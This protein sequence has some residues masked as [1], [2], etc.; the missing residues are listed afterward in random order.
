MRS[1]QLQRGPSQTLHMQPSRAR[2]CL[3][4]ALAPGEE[5][6]G[7]TRCGERP[8]IFHPLVQQWKS[9]ETGKPPQAAAFWCFSF[10]SKG[11]TALALSD[12]GS[13]IIGTAGARTHNYCWSKHISAASCS[14][15]YLYTNEYILYRLFLLERMSSCLFLDYHLFKLTATALEIHSGLIAIV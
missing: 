9:R 2:G 6:R 11:S 5:R 12:H 4:L 7:C 15:I 14:Q 3:H 10:L 1:L 8:G 13:L